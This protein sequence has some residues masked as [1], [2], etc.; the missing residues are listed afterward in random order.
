MSGDYDGLYGSFDY[1]VEYYSARIADQSAGP[2]V[3]AAS[4][5]SFLGRVIKRGAMAVSTVSSWAFPAALRIRFTTLAIIA[6]AVCVFTG[7][8]LWEPDIPGSGEW[9]QQY[10]STDP[11]TPLTPGGDPWMKQ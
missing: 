4:S 10:P 8:K 11:W 3:T 5:T 7:R 9:F 6:T 1:G 2:A